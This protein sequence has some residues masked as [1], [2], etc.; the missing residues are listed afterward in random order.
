[1]YKSTG[2]L[3]YYDTWL[4]AYIDPEICRYY[5]SL[6]PKY[7]Y[8]KKQ[9]YPPHIT[10]VRHGRDEPNYE[11]WGKYEGETIEYFY[12]PIIRQSENYFWLD[13]FSTRLEEI[14]AELGLSLES[15]YTVPPKGF[16]K[17]FHTT[18]GNMKNI[19]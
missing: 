10:V 9:M 1:M 14:R 18:L 6:I 3:K 5:F 4:V 11:F 17:T 13:V 19:I 16:R 15:P 12:R 2:K 7:Y 8:A